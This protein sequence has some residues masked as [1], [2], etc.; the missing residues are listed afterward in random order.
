MSE[1]I[2]LNEGLWIGKTVGSQRMELD[3]DVIGDGVSFSVTWDDP[4]GMSNAVV[5]SREEVKQVQAFL[6]AAMGDDDED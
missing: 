5:L 4:F 2:D 6:N 1:K 3:I